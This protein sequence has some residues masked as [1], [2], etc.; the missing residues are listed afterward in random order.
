MTAENISRAEWK[1]TKSYEQAAVADVKAAELHYFP[2]TCPASDW[3][4]VRT[5][6]QNRYCDQ[7]ERQ[8]LFE[9]TPNAQVLHYPNNQFADGIR[10]VTLGKSR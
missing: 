9:F 1:E 7:D 5:C 4:Y 8:I 6:S 2:S 10:A 3:S